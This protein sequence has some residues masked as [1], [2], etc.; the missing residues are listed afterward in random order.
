MFFRK[1]VFLITSSFVFT[2]SVYAAPFKSA[3]PYYLGAFGGASIA[4]SADLDA[5]GLGPTIGAELDLETGFLIGLTVG[6][7]VRKSTRVEAEFAIQKNSLDDLTISSGALSTSLPLSGD[8]K[9]YTIFANVWQDL[10]FPKVLNIVVN[11]FI[12]GGIG[13]S[14]RDLELGLPGFPGI[15]ASDS[16]TNLAF[17]FG[18]GLNFPW[19]VGS[20]VDLELSY[21]LRG[22]VDDALDGPLITH[23]LLGGLKY[24]F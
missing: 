2:S 10:P 18:A 5:S 11:P 19:S 9:Q 14:F 23:N 3:A 17:Q 1:L 8:L 16:D 20:P 22:L 13:V 7:F 6:K 24:K 4:G 15:T 21:R 12:G